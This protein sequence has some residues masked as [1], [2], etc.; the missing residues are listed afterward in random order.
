MRSLGGRTLECTGTDCG[1]ECPAYLAGVYELVGR[2]ERTY[3]DSF[4]LTDVRLTRTSGAHRS[5]LDF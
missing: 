5:V 2:V 4:G 3:D 1:I